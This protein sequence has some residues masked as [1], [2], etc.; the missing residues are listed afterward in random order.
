MLNGILIAAK[1][2]ILLVMGVLLLQTWH[3]FK[4]IPDDD[5]IGEERAKYMGQRLTWVTICVGAEAVLQIVSSILR[6]LEII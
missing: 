1:V 3:K 4:S 2:V 6:T 5:I